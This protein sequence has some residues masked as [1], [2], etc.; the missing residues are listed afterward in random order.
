MCC[1]GCLL[2]FQ[3]LVWATFMCFLVLYA[4]WVHKEAPF[5]AITLLFVAS[6]AFLEWNKVGFEQSATISRF[7]LAAFYLWISWG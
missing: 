3:K 2:A 5:S 1:R 6:S 7:L 4:G